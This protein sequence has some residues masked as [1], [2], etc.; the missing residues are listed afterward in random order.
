MVGIMSW[1]GRHLLQLPYS[2]LHFQPWLESDDKL[3]GNH[4]DLASAWVAGLPR[5]SPLDLEDAEIAEFNA[6]FFFQRIDDPVKNPFDDFV[7]DALSQIHV[8]GY[9]IDYFFLRHGLSF[10][11][12]SSLTYGLP[13]LWIA[14]R[15][16]AGWILRCKIFV[17]SATSGP[18][19]TRFIDPVESAEAFTNHYSASMNGKLDDIEGKTRFA[20]FLMAKRISVEQ[21]DGRDE[22]CRHSRFVLAAFSDAENHSDVSPR[23]ERTPPIIGQITVR[24][25]SLL[26]RD[27]HWRC[28][29]AQGSAEVQNQVLITP[30][31]DQGPRWRSKTR[32][33]PLGRFRL[34][35]G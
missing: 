21:Q 9:C 30:A 22:R 19:D 3:G 31:I 33:V 12:V 26:L 14:A 13:R 7:N 11:G 24:R 10:L 4:H 35:T 20:W 18:L 15:I 32:V 1:R 27:G 34:G 28:G 25:R 29:T 23:K 5:L 8:L 2:I 17:N 16:A 6:P